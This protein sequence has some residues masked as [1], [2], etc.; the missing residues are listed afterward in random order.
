[1]NICIFNISYINFYSFIFAKDNECHWCHFYL[2][3]CIILVMPKLLDKH[4][5]NIF[6]KEPQSL[7]NIK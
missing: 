6:I 1:M 5:K 7:V 2:L 3:N 4:Q